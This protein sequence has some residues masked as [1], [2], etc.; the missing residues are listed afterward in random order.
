[1]EATSPLRLHGTG[2]PQWG[3]LYNRA[4][5]LPFALAPELRRLVA[6]LH[7]QQVVPDDYAPHISLIYGNLPRDVGL[8]LEKESVP[9][10]GSIL[11][12]RCAAISIGRQ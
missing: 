10:E 7:P 3:P 12:D 11:F 9:F 4:F 1:A 2:I 8:Q 6:R 5:V